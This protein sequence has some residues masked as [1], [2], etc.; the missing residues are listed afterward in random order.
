MKKTL[1][2]LTI[3]ALC[4]TAVPVVA[5][6][7]DTDGGQ[8]STVGFDLHGYY[9]DRYYNYFDM[10]PYSATPSTNTNWWSWFDQRLDLQPTL[11]IADPIQ[12]V[13]E[14]NLLDD[15]SWGQDSSMRIPTVNVQRQ[16]GNA[17]AIQNVSYGTI[18]I[19]NGTIFSRSMS[20]TDNTGLVRVE[21][22][23]IRQLYA[24]LVLP[25]GYFRIGR[26]GANWG[27]GVFDN[28]GSPYSRF[29]EKPSTDVTD[30]N[31]GYDSN[32]GDFYDRVMFAS[33][34]AGFYYPMLYYDR[35][36]G[37]GFK[38]GDSDV[39]GLTF[40]NQF[41]DIRFADTGQFDAGFFIQSRTQHLVKGNYWF[42]DLWARLQYAGFLWEGEGVAYQGKAVFFK[43]RDVNLLTSYGLPVG[44]GGGHVGLDAYNALFRFKY[45]AGRWSTGLEYGFSSPANRD[46][47]D[48]YSPTA[49]TAITVA[50]NAL[51]S[52]PGNPVNKI[53][54]T[55]AVV[56]NQSAF[57]RKINTYSFNPEYKVDLI[58]W[59]QLMGG[60]LE[61]GMFI[62]V[63][64]NIHPLD[65][66]N[67]RLDIINSYI[68]Q[69]G[70]STRGTQA[71]HDLG[72]EGDLD[73]SYTFYK[74][75]TMDARFGYM[76]PG[77]YFRDIYDSVKNVY[78]LQMRTI[79]N[80]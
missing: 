22:F 79:V 60:A 27:M 13:S 25:I 64:G 59:D 44:N 9:R 38:I 28:S 32:T 11:I 53:N 61:N 66:M 52:D 41:R 40:A 58:T 75:F 68:N 73:Y 57:G 50:K 18:Y 1:L 31:A 49:Q 80:F 34:I 43:Q 74:Q 71:S 51:N 47:N 10:R 78:T 30:R 48:E 72:W 54:F 62:K 36:A 69:P 2:W 23:E 12:I 16:I 56:A 33:R 77:Q 55:N 21:P 35:I 26:Q 17:Q 63:G 29:M 24:R 19:P 7:E 8:L 14:F 39:N 65:G 5:M 67:V 15:V 45:D 6:A 20:T 4:A 3:V 46:P 70:L 76:L 37:Q 42:Y